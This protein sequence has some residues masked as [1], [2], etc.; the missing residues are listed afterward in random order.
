MRLVLLRH[1][2]T[3]GNEE[4]RYVG[5]RTDEPLSR[6]GVEQCARFGTCTD[7]DKVYVSPMLRARQTAELC[8]PRAR[9]LPVPGLE[10]FDFG[11][12]EG[13]TPDQMEH[14]AAYRTWVDGNC[15]G[16]CPGGESLKDFVR[17]TK[18]ALFGLLRAAN[19]RGEERV[20]VV[21]HGGTI[22]AAL[23]G[24]YNKHVGNCE[25]YEG[26]VRFEGDI[27]ILCDDFV[28]RG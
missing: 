17:R 15:E 4:H 20:V 3:A 13:R 1:A 2:A 28:I 19:K 25:G 23:D 14:D 10:E 22:M 26:T 6:R 5:M 27:A 9:I 18:D 16:Q 7:V 11:D 8:F 12:F 21:A 24:F